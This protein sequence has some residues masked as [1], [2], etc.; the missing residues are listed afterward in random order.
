MGD[1]HLLANGNS[2][3]SLRQ[4]SPL[5]QIPVSEVDVSAVTDGHGNRRNR[6]IWYQPWFD[7]FILQRK[8]PRTDP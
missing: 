7:A 6:G 2:T 5:R 1:N 4:L 3:L 8:Q